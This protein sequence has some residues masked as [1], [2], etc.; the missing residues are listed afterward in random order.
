[1]LHLMKTFNKFL[2]QVMSQQA[3]AVFLPHNNSSWVDDK[4]MFVFFYQP[5]QS[6]C[7]KDSPFFLHL[8]K[9]RQTYSVTIKTYTPR[10]TKE[11]GKFDPNKL[12]Y[13]SSA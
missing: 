7:R 11:E 10:K 3:Q 9:Y 12:T 2:L 4:L 6:P 13:T 1:M 8:K 5:N